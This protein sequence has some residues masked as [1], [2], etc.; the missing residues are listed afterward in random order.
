MEGSSCTGALQSAFNALD[1]FE[2]KAKTCFQRLDD[3]LVNTYTVGKALKDR[4]ELLNTLKDIESILIE[5]K[6]DQLYPTARKPN[7]TLEAEAESIRADIQKSNEEYQKMTKRARMAFDA[8]KMKL[9]VKAETKLA[10]GP[11]PTAMET[12]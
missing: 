3:S 1:E 7:D 10:R 12:I 6:L 11:P 4:D 2:M 5:A 9:P 8:L